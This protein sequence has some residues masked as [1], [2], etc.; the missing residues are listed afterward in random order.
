M[1]SEQK[2]VPFSIADDSKSATI[3]TPDT[4]SINTMKEERERN[5]YDHESSTPW[6]GN[7]YIIRYRENEQVLTFRNGKIILDK[8]GGLG[9]FRW[10][11]IQS[12]GWLGFQ[13]PAS[14]MKL[15][16]DN[17][18][19]LRC[20]V[21]HH[22]DWEYICPRKRMQGGYLLLVYRNQE[23]I[24]LKPC[25]ESS[26]DRQIRKVTTGDWDAEDLA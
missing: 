24:P 19:W 12:R 4:S 18:G 13:D 11:C 9:T 8:P 20:T 15:G 10:T 26:D 21:K 14:A 1:E 22:K 5:D 2:P 25:L 3:N 16:Y 23:L 7:T 6:P 17:G